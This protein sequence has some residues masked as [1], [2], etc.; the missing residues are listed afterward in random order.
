[1]NEW[2]T[3]LVSTGTTLESAL[4]VIDKS[5][6]RIGLVVDED[7]KLL[8]TLTDGDVRRALLKHVSLDVAV[9]EV[10]CVSPRT[11]APDWS[12]NRVLT[13]LEAE[14]LLHMP[15]VDAAGVVVGLQTLHGLMGKKRLTTPVFLMAGGFGTR[16]RP[17]TEQ[18][19]KPLLK[20]GDKPILELTL[21]RL[22]DAGFYNIYIS[23]HYLPE[24]IREHFG[25]GSKWGVKITYTHED[26]PLGTGGALGLLPHEEINEPLLL[27][28]GDLLTTVDFQSLLAFHN[29]HKCSA[30]MAVRTYEHQVPYGVVV[31]EDHCLRSIVEK[32][33]QKC[34]VNA[35]IYVLEPELIKN[36]KSGTIV[37]MPSLLQDCMSKGGEVS[38][39][40]LNE[41]WLDIGR[42]E[43][44]KRAQIESKHLLQ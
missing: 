43:D 1:M 30:T 44:F 3:V 20:V 39:F 26:A 4:A 37:D 2:Q 10:M 31:N 8:G 13:M 22:V 9:D 36:V 7:Q 14:R 6:L 29:K 11:A 25:D 5:A 18:C 27:M 24:M 35:G 42:I 16:L 19:P 34:F 38:T 40:P 17:L 21:E 32:P 15:V 12:R 33:L 28:N 23:T 41:F